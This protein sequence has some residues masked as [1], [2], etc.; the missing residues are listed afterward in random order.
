M[1]RRVAVTG[2][3]VVTPVGVCRD[4]F[5]S[6]L[7]EGRSGISNID[8]FDTSNLKTTIAGVCRDFRLEEFFDEREMSRLDRVSQIAVGATDM[9]I[10]DAGLE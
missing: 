10:R 5:W 7:V 8:G 2:I 4:R 1:M 6:A 9:A 3:G